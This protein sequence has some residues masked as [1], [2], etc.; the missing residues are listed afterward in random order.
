MGVKSLSSPIRVQVSCVAVRD[1][2]LAMIKRLDSG[3]ATS[4]RIIHAGGHV[5][6]GETLEEACARE[7]YE[8]TGLMV[9]DLKLKGVVSFISHTGSEY[10]SVCFFFVTHD[11]TLIHWNQ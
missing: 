8:E 2:N 9:E 4:G 1:G 10:H 6:L 11:V 7:M 3:R 5:E